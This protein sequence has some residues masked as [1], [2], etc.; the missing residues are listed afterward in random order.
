MPAGVVVIVGNGM[1]TGGQ[2]IIGAD[3][4]GCIEGA[5][6]QR[7]ENF[8][9]LHRHRRATGPPEDFTAKARNSHLQTLQVC[10]GIN[11]F[12]KPAEHLG[13]RIA[14]AHRYQIEGRI[15]LPPQFVASTEG[16]PCVHFRCGEAKGD[17][18]E[19]RGARCL[20]LPVVSGGMA[21]LCHAL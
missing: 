9:G 5:S 16:Q 4:F 10:E 18:C 15:N 1:V 17:G 8:A 3:K 13:A 19:K 20:S 14:A 7:R 21:D 11:F 2:I 6:L 12:V